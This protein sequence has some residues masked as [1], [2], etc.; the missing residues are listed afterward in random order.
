[1]QRVRD[2]DNVLCQTRDGESTFLLSYVRTYVFR[3]QSVMVLHATFF[4]HVRTVLY[5]TGTFYIRPNNI[6]V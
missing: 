3:H 1:M 4:Q 2:K 5:R 6:I